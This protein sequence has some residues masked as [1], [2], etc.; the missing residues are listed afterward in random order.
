[1]E[2]K[3]K[4]NLCDTFARAGVQLVFAPRRHYGLS[5]AV[6]WYILVRHSLELFVSQGLIQAEGKG[7]KD[8][9]KI[10]VE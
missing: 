1:M 3:T 10:K 4:R 2:R 5:V 7:N 9:N 6:W 8:G